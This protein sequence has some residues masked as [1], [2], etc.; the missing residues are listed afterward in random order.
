MG[1]PARAPQN[2]PAGTASRIDL[3]PCKEPVETPICSLE[4]NP[5][6]TGKL[7]P[8]TKAQAAAPTPAP[9]VSSG[10]WLDKLKET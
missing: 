7:T 1:M 4:H 6:S 5:T 9:S 3:T 8:P 2:A 10:Y